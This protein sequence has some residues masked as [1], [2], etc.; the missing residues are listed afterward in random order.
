M[1]YP[2]RILCRVM[3]VSPSS[4]YDY[5]AGPTREERDEEKAKLVID[6]FYENRRRAGS[7]PIAAKLDLGR[8][9]VMRL[10]RDQ[11]LKA[12]QPRAF[13]PRTTDSNHNERVSPNLLKDDKD[14]PKLSGEVLVGDITYVPLINGR[15]AYLAMFQDKLTRRII[16]WAIAEH[17]RAELVIEALRMALRRGLVKRNAII[18][19]D[20]GGQYV[21]TDYR[22]LLALHGLRQSM[23]AK[24]NCYD[25]AQ[26]ESFFSRF[27][28][29]LVEGGIFGSLTEARSETFSYIEGYYNLQRLHSGIGYLSPIEFE[30][31]LQNFDRHYE[32]D[33]QKEFL[34]VKTQPAKRRRAMLASNPSRNN[35]PGTH[36]YE[37]GRGLKISPNPIH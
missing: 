23:S 4:Y 3:K 11:G 13:V 25:N 28:T 16:G 18:H 6:C 15:W 34:D 36:Q 5:F 17:M 1:N 26:A 10:M 12:I 35:R 37:Q 31:W 2:V 9:V 29:E 30:N 24:G 32:I 7:R 19:T 20:R 8:W 14:R 33:I 22:E 27:K 21:A